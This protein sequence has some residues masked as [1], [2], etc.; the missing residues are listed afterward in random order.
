MNTKPWETSTYKIN[1]SLENKSCSKYD[2]KFFRQSWLRNY[3]LIINSPD[4]KNINETNLNGD[5]EIK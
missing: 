1:Y 2:F 3:D 4:W 5:F